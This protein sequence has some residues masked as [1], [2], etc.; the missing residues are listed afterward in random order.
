MGYTVHQ[1]REYEQ[2]GKA[3][4]VSWCA[5][6]LEELYFNKHNI[7]INKI[8]LTIIDADSWVPEVY[9]REVED[10]LFEP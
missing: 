3:S 9:I 8:L 1:L 5:E 7:D 6:H 4:N 2:R 10:H